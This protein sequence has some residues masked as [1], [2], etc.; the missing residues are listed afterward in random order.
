[1]MF[2][3]LLSGLLLVMPAM[4]YATEP[5]LLLK[6]WQPKQAVQG[7]LMSE[8]LDGVRARW[9]G[10]HLVSRGGH[11]FAAPA[12]FIQGFPPFA[13]D[14]ELWSKRGDFEHIVS[15]VRRKQPHDGWHQ[16]S[17]Q[18]FDVPNQTGGLLSRLQVLR[19]Y[20]GIHPNGY[21]HIIKQIPCH[22]Q[23]HLQAW[24]QTLVRQ[25]GEG[26]VVRQ[27]AVPYQTGRSS[28][29]LKVKPFLDT[30]CIIT[31]YKPGKGALRG[32][33]GALRCRM[34]DGKE[35]SIGSGLNKQLRTMPPAIGTMITFKYYGLT[36]YKMPRHPV[37][38]RVWKGDYRR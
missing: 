30:E 26:I 3:I 37:F 35:I 34:D 24:L 23:A 9:D 11:R 10:Q 15:I 6:V 18:I 29:A 14:G 22:G 16:L 27:P 38:L 12:W 21:I 7:W 25:G 36:K 33:T 28:N 19:Q 8:K 17:Y 5:M 4:T 2:T 32:N 31:G 20:L 13:L 1:M